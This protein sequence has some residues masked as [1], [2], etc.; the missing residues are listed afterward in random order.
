MH[1]KQ[2][3][4]LIIGF[5]FLSLGPKVLNAEESQSYFQLGI[6]GLKHQLKSG[7]ENQLIGN[8]VTISLGASKV[9][10]TY[11]Q[12]LSLEII[13]GPFQPAIDG[14]FE[15]DFEGTGIT[16][17]LLASAQDADL[18]SV[19]GS[20]GFALSFSYSDI[21]GRSGGSLSGTS[22][23]ENDENEIS[24]YSMRVNQFAIAPGLFFAWM[25]KKRQLTQTKAD[26]MTR[27]EGYFLSLSASIPLQVGYRST[28]EYPATK[29]QE[30]QEVS[31]IKTKTKGNLGGYS[32]I[33]EFMSILSV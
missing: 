19:S 25:Q 15:V 14:K 32:I 4:T 1:K 28:Y 7:N 23:L 31:V 13:Q 3:I 12:S 27:V 18:R 21:V 22:Y 5:I 33:I 11:A 26:L 8:A 6:K 30:T 10:K 24:A 17:S 9:E 20:Y 29:D 2:I 16:Y